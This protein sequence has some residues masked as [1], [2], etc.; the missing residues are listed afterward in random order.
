[1]AIVALA[2]G[3]G[4]NATVFTLVNAILIRGLPYQDSAYLY[5]LGSQDKDGNPNSVSPLDFQDWRAQS[6]AFEGLAAFSNNGVNVSDDRSA[7]QSARSAS[8]SS[9]VFPLLAVRPVIGR[10]FTPDDERTG[11]ESV[12]LIGHAMWKS[13][14]GEGPASSAR[15]SSWTASRPRSSA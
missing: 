8:L 10:N 2:L 14:Y 4:V 12:V 3:I 9:N 1:V 11:G 6:K 13:R 15:S 5:M 7:P